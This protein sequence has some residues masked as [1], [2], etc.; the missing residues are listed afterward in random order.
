M[1]IPVRVAVLL[2]L[3]SSIGKAQQGA[4]SVS[5]ADQV[6]SAEEAYWRCMQAHDVEHFV[7]LWSDD[8]VGWPLRKKHPI[9]KAEIV[10]DFKSGTSPLARA[11]AYE[12]HRESV[13]MHGSIGITFYRV[14]IH[15]RNAD[16]SVLTNTRRLSHT[17]MKNGQVW[18]IVAGM[19]APD[20]E[21]PNSR[22]P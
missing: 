22:K 3:A 14:E 17:W 7:A 5:D 2:L 19:S 21:P 6:W 9:H 8:F 11:I 13:E 18:Q 1:P 16:G 4:R 15:Q 20:G 12:L 10:S